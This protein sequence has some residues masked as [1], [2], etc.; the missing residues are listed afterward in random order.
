M[1]TTERA[2]SDILAAAKQIQEVGWTMR[3]QGTDSEFCDQLDRYATEYRKDSVVPQAKRLAAAVP[4]PLNTAISPAS[5]P[6]PIAIEPLHV[7][8][9]AVAPPLGNLPQRPAP[10]PS[11]RKSDL[12]EDLFADVMALTDEERI[13]LFT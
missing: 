5:A 11:A 2:I 3:E 7:L 13:A 10:V 4:A 12:A 9:L 6:A 1:Q 8:P